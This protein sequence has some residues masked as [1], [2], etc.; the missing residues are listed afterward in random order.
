MTAHEAPDYATAPGNDL[1]AHEQMYRNFLSLV[2]WS[3]AVA[4]IVLILLAY[5]LT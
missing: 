1:A 3:V 4:A 5:F 2:R